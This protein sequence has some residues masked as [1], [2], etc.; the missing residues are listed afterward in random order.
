MTTNIRYRRGRCALLAGVALALVAGAAAA[1]EAKRNFNIPAAPAGEALNAFAKQS[2]YRLL[3]PF[4]E[5]ASKLTRPVVGEMAPDAALA[6]LAADAG[7]EV[8]GRQGQVVTLR[9][10][11]TA[12]ASA[13]DPQLVDELVVTASKRAERLQN[14][15]ISVSASTGADLAHRGAARI[16][17]LAATT[18]G[19][20]NSSTGGGAKNNIIIRG[21]AT[22]SDTGL[23]Q[24]TVSLL[25]DDIELDPGAGGV[26]HTDIKITDVQRVEVLRG[27]QGTLFGSGSLSGAVR[28]I[29]N[30]P[31]P[32]AFGGAL[33]LTGAT[34]AHGDG[35]YSVDGA[36]NLPLV[37]DRAALRIVGY[38]YDDGGW[39]DNLT[40][41]E[42]DFNTQVTT[43]G[44]LML[45]VRPTD[46]LQVLATALTQEIN[47]DGVPGSFYGPRAG[48]ADYKREYARGAPF[49]QDVK[50]NIYNLVATYDL[51]AA[52]LTSNTSYLDK[53]ARIERGEPAY[54]SFL[55][56]LFGAPGLSGTADSN[57]P[58]R[59]HIFSEELRLASKDAGALKWSVGAFYQRITG[60]G[61]QTI[62]AP[63]LLP[64]IGTKNLA[65]LTAD[66]TQT[67]KAITA[68][69]VY[70]VSDRIDLTAG[71]RVGRSEIGF[72]TRSTGLFLTGALSDSV[73]VVTDGRRTASSVNP[74]FAVTFRQSPDVTWYAQAARGFRSGGPNLTAGLGGG[75]IPT[76]YA[77]DSL[78]NYELGS[79][80]RLLDGRLRVQS[81]A[82][83]IAWSNIQA[84]LAA[85]NTTYTGN[86][87]DA[88]IYGFETE[89]AASPLPWLDVGGT[90]TLSHGELTKDVPTLTRVT[91]QIGVRSGEQL[92][93][94][95]E[96]LLALYAEGA[97]PL[98]G[99]DAYLRAT[100][101][102]VGASYTDFGKQ[103]LKAGEF[104][105]VDL[106]AGVK[107]GQVEAALFVDNLL[108][109]EGVQA[110]TDVNF[111]GPVEAIPATAFRIRPRTLG[112]TL[113]ASF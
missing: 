36:L 95:P 4:D 100:Y 7:L 91:G 31:D 80:L 105:Q 90:L 54:I 98:A 22:S 48:A 46:R 86:A 88:R 94:S 97:F 57:I 61:G 35:S 10:A 96:Q 52:T 53:R 21:V 43:G 76:T 89:V 40:T 2:G 106:R 62:D 68:E 74:R 27:P 111:L 8:A 9:V 83:Y 30:K 69:G 45:L 81:A 78:W 64:L 99:H 55:G 60:S 51:D 1:Q 50:S 44:R 26:A 71:V 92:P 56:L 85:N 42:R 110:A 18:P 41:G 15:P 25:L 32:T 20:Y 72:T 108:D 70:T 5:V 63:M 16:D 104:G 59:S 33:N 77:S 82:Y 109:G 39:I 29:S 49:A 37:A 6:R 34:T 84:S 65:T 23:N 14:V 87:G 58:N 47:Q 3:F 103:G 102:Y 79:K 38:R 75:T 93:A 19:L 67:E 17:D 13:P 112:V 107:L 66:S 12:R 73:V 101:R 113:R 11:R 24:T 28:F